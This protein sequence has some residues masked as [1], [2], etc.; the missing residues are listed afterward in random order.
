MTKGDEATCS[1][2]DQPIDFIGAN[3]RHTGGQQVGHVALP[4]ENDM[5]YWGVSLDD[6]SQEVWSIRSDCVGAHY[7]AFQGTREEARSKMIAAFAILIGRMLYRANSY[8]SEWEEGDE[9]E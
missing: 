2:C 1:I 5:E 3:W 7:I 9:D 8:G 6:L 4:V